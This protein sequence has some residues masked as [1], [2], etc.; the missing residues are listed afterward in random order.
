MIGYLT[1]KIISKKPTQIMLDVNGVGYLINIT[2][3]TFEFLPNDSDQLVSLHTYLSVRED[4]LILFGFSTLAEKEMF[5]LLIGVNGVGPKSAQS[6][7]S[8]IQI[9][10]L[11]SALRNNDLSRIIAIPGIGR[12]T[13][14]RLIIELRDKVEKLSD[15]FELSN[16][17]NY[18]IKK[19]AILALTQL[20]YNQKAADKAVRN[21]LDEVEKP[22][23]EV[24]LKN[25]L[26]LLNKWS[27]FIYSCTI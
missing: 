7:L 15:S 2:I 12:K 26:A 22:T 17:S 10:E 6:I 5:E 3:S 8:G 13:G 16:D 23:L 11:H 21:V 19:D 27:I 24:L 9:D 14:E 1:G 4:A 20:G 25:A 18:S